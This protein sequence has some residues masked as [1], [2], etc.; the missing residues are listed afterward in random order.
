MIKYVYGVK[1]IL[2]SNF[3]NPQFEVLDKEQAIEAYT[4]S[5]KE[6]SGEARERMRELD[7]YY[8]GTFDTTTGKCE[9]IDPEFMLS[10]KAIIDGGEIKKDS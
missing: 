10:F 1:N 3:G 9:L 8:L 2:S 6:A 5:A 4:I 7:L